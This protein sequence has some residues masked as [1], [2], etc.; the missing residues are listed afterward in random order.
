MQ[1]AEGRSDNSLQENEQTYI[2]RSST[3]TLGLRVNDLSV[4]LIID[5]QI[6]A[7][8]ANLRLVSEHQKIQIVGV[9][10]K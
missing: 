1:I 10:N 7:S 6:Y 4:V 5:K 2:Y 8:E 3:E 9:Y